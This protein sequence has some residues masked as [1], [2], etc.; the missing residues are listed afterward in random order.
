[1]RFDFVSVAVAFKAPAAVDTCGP[2]IVS[3]VCTNAASYFSFSNRERSNHGSFWQQYF[4]LSRRPCAR[5][6][7]PSF[8]FFTFGRDA[9]WVEVTLKVSNLAPVKARGLG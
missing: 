3:S 4:C 8:N 5:G 7:A 2:S 6:S 9:G 1:M